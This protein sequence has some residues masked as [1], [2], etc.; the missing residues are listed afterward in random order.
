[1]LPYLFSK[2]ATIEKFN[3][4]NGVVSRAVMAKQN[5]DRRGGG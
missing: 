1:M 3:N 5:L 4:A 2:S